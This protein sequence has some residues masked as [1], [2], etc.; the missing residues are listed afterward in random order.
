MAHRGW[1][2]AARGDYP[3]QDENRW[4]NRQPKLIYV[5]DFEKQ[6]YILQE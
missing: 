2:I 3:D 5:V 6:L 1:R 4:T